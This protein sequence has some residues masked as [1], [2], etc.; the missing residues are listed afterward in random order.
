MTQTVCFIAHGRE[1][2]ATGTFNGKKVLVGSFLK[3]TEDRKLINVVSP[4]QCFEVEAGSYD[5]YVRLTVT[6]QGAGGVRIT[7]NGNK[8]ANWSRSL[9]QGTIREGWTFPPE[10]ILIEAL[11]EATTPEIEPEPEEEECF[12]F[13]NVFRMRGST[14]EGADPQVKVLVSSGRISCKNI[15]ILEASGSIIEEIKEKDVSPPGVVVTPQNPFYRKNG[16]KVQ[17]TENK[18]GPGRT[19][20]IEIKESLGFREIG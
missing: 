5:M 16:Q 20:R 1:V 3:R 8:I 15:E 14:A 12:K 4:P 13:V 19:L 10:K 7:N 6:A 9:A 17:I 11:D 18:D 2:R